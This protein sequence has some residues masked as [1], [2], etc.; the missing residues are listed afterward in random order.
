MESMGPVERVLR[1]FE[2]KPV[3]RVPCFCAMMESRTA[4]EVLGRPLLP[5]DT[6][7]GLPPV[8]FFLDRW[9]PALTPLFVRPSLASVLHR[10]NLGQIAMGFDAIWAYMDDTWVF[11]DAK[12][13]ALTTGSVF[14][15]IPDGYGNLT[16]MYRGPG[17]TTPEEFDAWPHWL[18]SVV[19]MRQDEITGLVL[20]CLDG[21]RSSFEVIE[22]A[23]VPGIEIVGR[24]FEEGE[25][26]LADLILAGEAVGR[27]MVVL[28]DHI[29]PGDERNRG[30]GVSD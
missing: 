22:N 1:T 29:P 15:V 28:R 6:L 17:I 27:A 12:T 18:Y 24:R 20:E 4:N 9:G 2:G 7:M 23:V 3:D 5:M 30:S 21:G 16:Y 26:F 13:I 14:N 11:L 8:R 25:F 19:N 10:R